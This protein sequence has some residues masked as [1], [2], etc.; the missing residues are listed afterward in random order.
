MRIAF[1]TTAFDENRGGSGVFGGLFRRLGSRHEITIVARQ[2]TNDPA[3]RSEKVASRASHSLFWYT[4]RQFARV[5]VSRVRDLHRQRPFDLIVVNQVI[6]SAVAGLKSLGAPVLY[7]IHHPVSVDIELAL[8]ESGGMLERFR[9]RLAYGRMAGV[10]RELVRTFDNILTVSEAARDRIVADYGIAAGKVSVIHN[11][12][13]TDFFRR[14]RAAEP[15][16]VIALGSY[17]HPRRGFPYLVRAYRQLAQSG[18]RILDVGRRTDEQD[19]VLRAIPGVTQFGL[20]ESGT[21]PDLYSRASV[22]LSTSLYEGFG[23]AIAEALACETPC[24]AFGAGGVVDVLGTIDPNLMVEARDV[25]AL[26]E[27][28]KTVEREGG[29][30]YR[31]AV[32]RHFGI[33]AMARS[34]EK[35][36]AD[37]ASGKLQ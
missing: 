32:I 35:L 22:A 9:W 24:V 15:K 13:D 31:D 3:W 12:I 20:V 8:G 23:L 19:A 17:Q 7:V 37:L 29:A 21:I 14:T 5:A 2:T 33:E 25:D 34:Y 27:R 4:E 10:Q 36:F 11:G 30:R 16:T 28:V 18:Y 26:V 1:V 6:G